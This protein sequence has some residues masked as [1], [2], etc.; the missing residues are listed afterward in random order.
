MTTPPFSTE[1]GTTFVSHNVL[2][3]ADSGKFVPINFIFRVATA[4]TYNFGI[5]VRTFSQ[6]TIRAQSQHVTVLRINPQPPPPPQIS[7]Q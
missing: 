5:C 4:G 7:P 2:A 1:W 6:V 3:T